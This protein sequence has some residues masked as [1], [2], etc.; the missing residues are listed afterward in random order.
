MSFHLCLS[1]YLCLPY[2][3]S[4]L[5]LVYNQTKGLR[6]V[7]IG[8]VFAI[9]AGPVAYSSSEPPTWQPMILSLAHMHIAVATGREGDFFVLVLPT[10]LCLLASFGSQPNEGPQVCGDWVSF[11]DHCRPCGMLFVRASCL[12]ATVCDWP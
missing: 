1:P 3:A 6:S 8:L 2:S 7:E 5:P 11:R 9:I 4:W 10:L 12:A